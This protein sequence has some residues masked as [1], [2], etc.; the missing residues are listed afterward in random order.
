MDELW[1]AQQEQAD[2]IGDCA[3]WFQVERPRLLAE[4]AA[5]QPRESNEDI[6]DDPVE[7]S[8]EG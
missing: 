1:Q 7:V 6:A 4:K 5:T 8:E 3:Y 2:D